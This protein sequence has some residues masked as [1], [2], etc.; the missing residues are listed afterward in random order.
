LLG[1]FFKKKYDLPVVIDYRD[2]WSENPGI[3]NNI[4]KKK[5]NLT[6]EK[7]CLAAADLITTASYHIIK[8]IRSTLGSIAEHKNFFGFPYGYN[9]RYFEEL[10]QN[11]PIIRNSGKIIGTF[12]GAVHGDINPELILRGIKLAIKSNSKIHKKL[13]INCYGTLFGSSAS[14]KNIINKHKLNGI[15]NFHSFLPYDSFLKTLRQSS[16]L[17]LPHGDSPIAKVLY[18]TKLFDYLGVKRPI[19]YIGGEGQVAETINQCY[20][21]VCTTTDAESI[22]D[23]LIKIIQEKDKKSWYSNKI[24]Y[25][26][27]DRENIFSDLCDELTK[28]L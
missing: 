28:L 9:G 15:I 3:E 16:F 12:A 24:A 23:S 14:P 1:P 8:Y 6:L 20:A 17:I 2:P 4:I 27:F 13:Q 26:K 10:I 5:V 22:S 25:K 21:G 18:P 11:V 7:K 19:L